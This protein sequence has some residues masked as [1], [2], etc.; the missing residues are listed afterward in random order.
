MFNECDGG[1][2]ECWCELTANARALDLL[3]IVSCLENCKCV[4]LVELPAGLG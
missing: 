2:A 3:S 1:I 4:M